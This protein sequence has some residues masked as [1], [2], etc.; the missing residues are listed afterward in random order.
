MS[1]E[2]P[3]PAD[4]RVE[5]VCDGVVAGWAWEPSE[6]GRPV[7]VGVWIDG[8]LVAEAAANLEAPGLAEIGVGD[9]HHAFAIELPAELADGREH[10]ITVR[11]GRHDVTVPMIPTWQ[12]PATGRWAGTTF[13]A[14]DP[15]PGQDSHTPL[16]DFPEDTDERANAQPLVASVR[17]QTAGFTASRSPT[18]TGSAQQQDLRQTLPAISRLTC[19]IWNGSPPHLTPWKS[20]SSSPSCPARSSSVRST[21]PRMR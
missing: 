7:G 21:P 12:T 3:P 4:G 14:V 17:G 6:P 8:V 18:F 9:G 11:A 13:V 19:R 15:R 2:L 5:S 10:T 16:I 1:D 20:G